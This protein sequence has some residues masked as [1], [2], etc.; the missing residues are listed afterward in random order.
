[1]RQQVCIPSGCQQWVSRTVTVGVDRFAYMSSLAIYV[2]SSSSFM[3]LAILAKHEKH[4]SA[5]A[6]SPFH[7]HLLAAA[8]G[9][10][11]EMRLYDIDTELPVCSTSYSAPKAN[12]SI[13]TWHRTQEGVLLLAAGSHLVAWDVSAAMDGDG[14]SALQHTASANTALPS[15]SAAADGGGGGGL[16]SRLKGGLGGGGGSGGAAVTEVTGGARWLPLRDLSHPITA[17]E[18]CPPSAG[19]GGSGG[20]GGGVNMVAVATGDGKV[21][22]LELE[23]SGLGVKYEMRSIQLPDGVPATSVAW[24]PLSANGLLLV[25]G[26]GGA[27]ALY[28]C[29]TGETVLQYAKQPAT[30]F[31]CAQFVPSQPGNFLLSSSRSGALQLWN[32]SQPQP[33]RLLKP[34]GGLVQGFALLP[35]PQ[36]PG[37]GG[38]AGVQ[39]PG[40]R[41]PVLVSFADGGVCVF[42]LASQTTLWRQEGG[43]TETIFDCR[44]CTTDPNLLATASFDSSVR[45]WDVRT[46]RCI[47]QLGG[48]EGILYSVSWSAD[49]KLLA[50]S[51]DSGMIYIYDYAR[52][53]LIKGLRQH[54][55]QS[56]K[57]AFH[58]VKPTL[59]ASSS[60]DG[61]VY[62]YTVDGETVRT[63]RHFSPVSCIAWGVLCPDMV[64]TTTEHGELHIWDTSLPA[65]ECL[66]RTLEAHTARTFNVEFSPLVKH[67]LLSSSNDRTARVWDVS[68][69]ECQVVLQ[70]HGAEVRAVAWHPEVATIC[71]TGSWD[72]AVRV[73]DVRNGRCLRVANDH[74]AD[75]YG[76]ACHPARPFF[77]VTCSRDTTLRLWSTLDLTP[78]LFP[79]ALLLPLAK[80]RCSAEEAVKAPESAPA[81]LSGTVSRELAERLAGAAMGPLERFAALADFFM[82]PACQ[83]TFW[84]LARAVKATAVSG[85]SGAPGGAA[86]SGPLV[87]DL[88]PLGYASRR[89]GSSA[90]RGG[91]GGGGGGGGA[92]EEAGGGGALHHWTVARLAVGSAANH[93]E[94][95]ASSKVRNG[96]AS[97]REELLREA[98][99]QH[100]VAGNVEH[101]CELLAE[102]GDWDRALALAP[103]VGLGLWQRLMRQRVAALASESQ[104]HV[105]D[106]L[107]L[108][109]VSGAVPA[110]VDMLSASQLYDTAFNVAAVQA[111]GGYASLSIAA[112][113]AGAAGGSGG[114]G[115]GGGQGW[116]GGVGHSPG[117]RCHS[118]GSISNPS[119]S[120]VGPMGSDLPPSSPPGVG[121]S[122]AGGAG[123]SAAAVAA[124]SGGGS[125]LATLTSPTGVSGG[126]AGGAGTSSGGST[127]PPLRPGGLP[128]LGRA[129]SLRPP[130]LAPIQTSGLSFGGGA[131]SGGAGGPLPS[132]PP[133]GGSTTP[134]GSNAAA[135]G[136]DSGNASPSTTALRHDGSAPLPVM[137]APVSPP[138]GPAPPSGS[139]VSSSGQVPA[140]PPMAPAPPPGGMR[141]APSMRGR[142]LVAASGGGA[143]GAANAAAAAAASREALERA[144]SV[145]CSQARVYLMQ[146]LPMQ[147]ACCALSVD[148]V[149]GAVGLLLRGGCEDAALALVMGLTRP[150]STMAAAGGSS[151]IAPGA[152]G[153]SLAAFG[154]GVAAAAAHGGGAAGAGAGGGAAGGVEAVATALRPRVMVAAAQRREAAGDFLT[155]AE[156]LRQLPGAGTGAAGGFLRAADIRDLLAGRCRAHSDPLVTNRV[157]VALGLQESATYA[158]P[159]ATAAAGA[160]AAAG[161]WDGFRA[162]L[163]GGAAEAAA[164]WALKAAAKLVDGGRRPTLASPEWEQAWA[165]LNSLAPSA[166]GRS[167]WLEVFGLAL[168]AGALA[169]LEQGCAAVGLYLVRTLEAWAASAPGACLPVSQARLA[170][171]VSEGLD[172]C[173]AL[174]GVCGGCSGAEVREVLL[175][176]LAAPQGSQW[177]QGMLQARLAAAEARMAGVGGATPPTSPPF[178]A[179]RSSQSTS[180][181]ADDGPGGP[182]LA[183]LA[184]G[185]MS[186]SARRL[187]SLGGSVGTGGAAGRGGG[188][189]LGASTG[190]LAAGGAVAAA[191][192]A[193]S[194][195]ASAAAAAAG[196]GAAGGT[197]KAAGGGGSAGAGGGML[198]LVDL[199]RG[200]VV[201]AAAHVPSRS[202]AMSSGALP[203]SVVSG[204]AIRGPAV[205][206]EG[207]GAGAGGG[208]GGGGVARS[209]V[210]MSLSEAVALRRVLTYSPL[211]NGKLLRLP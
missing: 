151:P 42:D 114:G 161:A 203:V 53:M 88:G 120:G 46:A 211:G 20:G 14:H 174:P 76:I 155:A 48:A 193:L 150:L 95:A 182:N 7:S 177:M 164:E 162:L 68:T 72:W 171:E 113:A 49:G 173:L 62:V 128:A 86:D 110:L 124:H 64:A 13:I 111:S 52:G 41:T 189:D 123:S 94:L 8:I 50:A 152:A 196:D 187:A 163:L 90:G 180:G 77:I 29:G 154:L 141:S 57:V 121:D 166:L 10:N 170:A 56:L 131:S 178:V 143:A 129:P 39:G 210:F 160:S 92:G 82:P 51:N 99:Q 149:G 202:T 137:A 188:L 118:A 185:S 190:R 104:S 6:L 126:G 209:S 106:V 65:A 38:G 204:G 26:R 83:D 91:P 9:T 67:W 23:P 61:T 4:L 3:P 157:F 28:D 194:P 54:T 97:R 12:V 33:L 206:L 140:P 25:V 179:G 32:V 183:A 5:L 112:L 132:P 66:Q 87:T 55:K 100:L 101:C 139:G 119:G 147:A 145:R 181:G 156:L 115:G 169:A 2:Y 146:G 69:G 208:G 36:Q 59:L 122:G 165:A 138:L 158:S 35:Q 30:A 200:P 105:S 98:A 21:V 175:E 172:A 135:T 199:A 133:T 19:G 201:V 75:V 153:V 136:A 168:Y 127:L 43:H 27:L 24:E 78:H 159:A 37:G 103:V 191:L 89:R 45:V 58:P 81:Q 15:P 60:V 192:A 148:D 134:M 79:Q 207:D 117:D 11:H 34:A 1:M 16:F 197:G 96:G 109:L 40:R 63:L 205:A 142:S 195:G 176:L 22:L 74:H 144:T 17:F 130:P 73:W 84:E 102:L 31:R 18:Q 186:R 107:P 44:F 93:L 85:I 125:L 108:Y 47:K 80:L 184:G 198:N 116:A 167:V 71:F 70:G